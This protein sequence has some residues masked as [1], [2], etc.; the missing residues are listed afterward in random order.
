MP[1]KQQDILITIIV[2]SV[3]F[4]LIGIFL[5]VLLFLFLRRQRKNQRE[6]EEMQ[7]NFDKAILNTQIEIQDQTLSYIASEIHDNI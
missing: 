6:K 2:A 3:F 1:E 4:V 7:F 5:L